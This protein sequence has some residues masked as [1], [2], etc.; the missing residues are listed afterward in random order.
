[1]T[2]IHAEDDMAAQSHHI[3]LDLSP[4]E[5]LEQ[6]RES[7]STDGAADI[8]DVHPRTMENWRHARKGPAYILVAGRIRYLRSDL[9]A[10]L[11][12]QR[13]GG[14]EEQPSTNTA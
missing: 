4:E 13:R 8:L 12:R 6:W 9:A 2:S 1:M 14:C 3:E 11:A 7:A 5:I 10:W